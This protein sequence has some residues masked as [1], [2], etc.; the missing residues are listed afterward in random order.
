MA[1]GR[2]VDP[3]DLLVRRGDRDLLADARP[4]EL[5][6][7]PVDLE[8]RAEVG[9][10]AA[11]PVHRLP[12]WSLGAVRGWGFAARAPRSRDPGGAGARSL[13]AWGTN[14]GPADLHPS[15]RSRRS[16]PARRLV[17]RSD[18]VAASR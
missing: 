11:G 3:A 17:R 9:A 6:V 16:M 8:Q 13:D 7:R 14:R 4:A 12:R 18:V 15:R 2:E 1:M 5:A 10:A